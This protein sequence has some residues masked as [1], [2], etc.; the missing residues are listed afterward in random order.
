VHDPV[1]QPLR[2]LPGDVREPG[3]DFLGYL[4]GGFTEHGEV[5]QQG[6]PPLP[7]GFELG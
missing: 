2:L 7:V 5:P 1:L 3:L 4:A 6:V